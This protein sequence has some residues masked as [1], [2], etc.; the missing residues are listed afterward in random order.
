MSATSTPAADGLT[1]LE[2]VAAVDPEMRATPSIPRHPVLLVAVVGLAGMSFARFGVEPR[3]FIAAFATCTLAVL[4]AIDIEHRLLPNRILL[5]A[6]AI[7]LA[8]QLA[9]YPGQALEHLLAGLAA[10]AFLAF[11]LVVRR[12]AMG[13]GD[14]K[15]AVLLGAIVG[16]GV[17][18]AIVIGCVATLPFALAM[19]LR[20]GSIRGATLPFGPFLAFGT[21]VVLFASG[22]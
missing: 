20:D 10:A 5:P 7:V 16:W 13:M 15:L 17:F 22:A 11:P 4:A 9:F 6:T 18:G 19:R 12:D 14:I 2:D 1:D 8:A 3:A 21:L